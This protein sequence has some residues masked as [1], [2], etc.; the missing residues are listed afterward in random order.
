[1]LLDIFKNKKVTPSVNLLSPAE[2]IE[3]SGNYI[4]NTYSISFDGE[5]TPGEIGV[6]KN[7]T[8]D[9]TAL[10]ARSWQSFFESEVTQTVVKKFALWIVGSGLKLQSE[11][12]IPILNNEGININKEEVTKTIESRFKIWSDSEQ[13]DYSLNENFNKIS[14]E[15]VKNAIVGGDVLC[16]QRLDEET[17][18]VNEE[19]IDGSHIITPFNRSA[20]E[21][22][23]I[24]DGVE[25]DK[26]GRHVAFWVCTSG[27]EFE[28]ISARDSIGHKMAF[29]VY[30][31]KYRIDDVRGMPLITSV[32]E[33]LKKLDRYK[34]ATVGSA[35][36]VA[37]IAITIENE[38]N[39]VGEDPMNSVRSGLGFAE[40]APKYAGDSADRIRETTQKQVIN[41][42]PG[43]KFKQI[44]SKNQLYF[45]DFYDTNFNHVCAAIGI[46]PDVALSMYNGSFSSSRAAIK[47]WEHVLKVSRKHYS[48][49][50]H[51]NVYS[52]WLDVQVLQGKIKIPGYLEAL[53][54][55]DI[56]VLAAYKNA[57]F[58]GASV[59][60]I[61]PV[62][63]VEA[64]RRKLGSQAAH[65]PLTTVEAATERLDGGDSD[66]NMEQVTE[67]LQK[68]PEKTE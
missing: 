43:Q 20:K 42:N 5:K 38:L 35:E 10:R 33:T 16:I 50:I 39:A 2:E 23:I 61:D 44:E 55:N 65:V 58:V 66:S 4:Q 18:I 57:R 46:P 36:E 52:L 32:L 41:G 48:D 31:C 11:P 17:G 63:E 45:K 15:C 22:N 28:R 6:I 26:R 40:S 62:K 51:K 59:P 1:M 19:L 14:S 13:S 25:I 7:Y 34:E 53:G 68:F 8:A 56:E 49:Q 64:E 9:F 60:H 29:M 3:A 24:R 67:E 21:G 12:L 37:K 30:G 47:D 27:I 54:R